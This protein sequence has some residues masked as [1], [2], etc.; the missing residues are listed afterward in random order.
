M[1]SKIIYEATVLRTAS[2]LFQ[3]NQWDFDFFS[4][5]SSMNNNNNNVKKKKRKRKKL[6]IYNVIITRNSATLL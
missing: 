5:R 3:D 6:Y 1:S 4:L 2:R